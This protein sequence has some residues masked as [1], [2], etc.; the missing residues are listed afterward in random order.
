MLIS[1]RGGEVIAVDP[2][3]ERQL[4]GQAAGA[5]AVANAYAPEDHG[6]FDIVVDAAG[7]ESTWRVGV[8][9]VRPNGEVV[10]L[11][12]GQPEGSFPMATV[13][14]RA[15]RLRGH[16]AY[17]RADFDAALEVLADESLSFA[18]V[19]E[20]PLSEGAAAFYDLAERPA[21]F[22]KVLLRP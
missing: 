19:E 22:T 7:F 8:E 21:Q 5:T 6:S 13:V 9:A 3:P 14:R 17:S 16:F 11:G 15:I 18:W 12:L 4:L 10:V 2:L 1:R 20:L